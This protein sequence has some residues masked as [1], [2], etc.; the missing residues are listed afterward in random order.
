MEVPQSGFAPDYGAPGPGQPSMDQRSHDPTAN[1]SDSSQSGQAGDKK[2]NKL[3][4]HRTS[5]ACDQPPS[6]ATE[7]RP[8]PQPRPTVGSKTA[9]T[10]SSPVILPGQPPEGSQQHQYHQG[11]VLPSS[12]NVL[13]TTMQPSTGENVGQDTTASSGPYDFANPQITNWMSPDVS[14]SSTTKSN[15][16]EETWK[17]YAEQSPI[18]PSFSPYTSQ[19]PP[20]ASWSNVDANTHSNMG[21][22]SFAIGSSMAYPRGT[23]IPAQYPTM[24]Q[25]SRQF[26]QRSLTV[27][28]TDMYPNQI[29]T[30]FPTM[31]PHTTSLSVGANP[32]SDYGTWPQQQ[33]QTQSPYAYSRPAEGYDTWTHDEN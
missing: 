25:S 8:K 20:S 18:T 22:S 12:Q 19:A 30:N 13:P 5:V 24:P 33:P 10:S 29:A 14:P 26:D 6:Q 28:S 23:Q 17:S 11:G 16:H 32:P 1:V 15:D 31:D 21:Y 4:Y 9:S 2:R 27:I 7:P 3:G